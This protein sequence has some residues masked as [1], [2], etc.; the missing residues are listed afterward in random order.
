MRMLLLWNDYI[1]D[2]G[3]KMYVNSHAEAGSAASMLLQQD[4]R[5]DLRICLIPHNE[6]SDYLLLDVRKAC[7]DVNVADNKSIGSLMRDLSTAVGRYKKAHDFERSF[8]NGYDRV[9]TKQR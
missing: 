5:H 7:S 2:H 4:G 1:T 3:G 6:T 9:I 8:I